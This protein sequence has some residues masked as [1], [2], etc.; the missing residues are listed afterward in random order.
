MRCQVITAVNMK[1]TAFCDIALCSLVEVYRRFRGAYNLHTRAMMAA[2][3]TSE[4]SPYFDTTW[5]YIPEG[6]HLYINILFG[7]IV[8]YDH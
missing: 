6:Y 7:L 2:V 5:R 4:T 1:I 8:K 3:G